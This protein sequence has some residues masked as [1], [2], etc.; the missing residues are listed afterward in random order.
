MKKHYYFI[1]PIILF[2]YILFQVFIE[3][4]KNFSENSRINEIR[5]KNESIREENSLEKEKLDYLVTESYKVK[6]AKQAKKF[7]FPEEK[8]IQITERDKIFAYKST[9]EIKESKKEIII[10]NRSIPDKWLSLIKKK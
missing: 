1:I 6:E 4:Y 3:T 5:Q 2:L 7:K 8:S 9:I 10:D